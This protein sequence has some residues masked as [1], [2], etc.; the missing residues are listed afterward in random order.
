MKFSKE[1]F[2]RKKEGGNNCTYSLVL[3]CLLR[4]PEQ[5][6]SSTLATS[7]T[8]AIAIKTKKMF[9]LSQRLCFSLVGLMA[10]LFDNI[11]IQ[12]RMWREENIVQF[13]QVDVTTKFCIRCYLYRKLKIYNKNNISMM[14]KQVLFDDFDSMLLSSLNTTLNP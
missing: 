6:M 3:L 11:A 2:W 1:F 13:S 12:W 7:S 14:F 9:K 4:M 10:I 5:K 8:L